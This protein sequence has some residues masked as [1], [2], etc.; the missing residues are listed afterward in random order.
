MAANT[1]KMNNTGSPAAPID[2]SKAQLLALLGISTFVS[3]LNAVSGGTV[4]STN[5]GLGA[6]PAAYVLKG[7]LKCAVAD[8]GY[9]AGDVIEI[10]TENGFVGSNQVGASAWCNDTQVGMAIASALAVCRKDNGGAQQIN[11]ASWNTF[12]VLVYF[13]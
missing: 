6:R 1:V 12:V 5:H 2:G 7:Y 3:G 11:S 9:A 13:A 8:D 4:W 10:P